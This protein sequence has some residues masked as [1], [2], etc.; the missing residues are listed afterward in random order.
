MLVVR[1]LLHDQ[2][3][4]I[5]SQNLRSWITNDIFHSDRLVKFVTLDEINAPSPLS[6]NWRGSLISSV[7]WMEIISVPLSLN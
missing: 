3:F 6:Q 2:V 4:L 5:S 7:L 1:S